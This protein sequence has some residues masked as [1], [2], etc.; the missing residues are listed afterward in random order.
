MRRKKLLFLLVTVLMVTSC[1]GKPSSTD[2]MVSSSESIMSESSTVSTV[3]D[4]IHYPSR[5]TVSKPT[6]I[7]TVVKDEAYYASLLQQVDGEKLWTGNTT[8]DKLIS[9]AEVFTILLDAKTRFNSTEELEDNTLIYTIGDLLID[10]DRE[11]A[12][13]DFDK[14][15]MF[16]PEDIVDKYIY[17]IFNIKY[18]CSKLPN[19]SYEYGGL[20]CKGVD[21]GGGGGDY[22]VLDYKDKGD[23]FYELTIKYVYWEPAFITNTY[24][25][26]VDGERIYIISIEKGD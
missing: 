25:F 5:T 20:W 1:T 21:Y 9:F 3:S 6:S 14:E 2:S 12:I 7:A 13:W 23:G 18:D 8:K 22:E 26:K 24:N 15:L 17:Y 4:E 19:Y 11:R 16:Y 10:K